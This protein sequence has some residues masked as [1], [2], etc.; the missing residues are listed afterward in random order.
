MACS[1]ERGDTKAPI[2]LGASGYSG[3]C[4]R[5]EVDPPSAPIALPLLVMTRWFEC[6]RW[7][8]VPGV[9]SRLYPFLAV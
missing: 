3:A 6:G 4:P 8:Q 1:L 7:S 5:V 9:E 2:L